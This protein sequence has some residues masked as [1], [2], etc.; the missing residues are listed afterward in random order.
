VS[1]RRTPIRNMFAALPAGRRRGFPIAFTLAERQEISHSVA[2]GQ[3]IRSTA[4][5]LGRAPSTVGRELRRNGGQ[6]IEPPRQTTPPGDRALR[7]KCCKLDN[8]RALAQIVT[9]KL[10][11]LGK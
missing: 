10:R 9:A 7:P 4:A 2:E 1:A 8:N 5:W 11:L 3:S 6:T